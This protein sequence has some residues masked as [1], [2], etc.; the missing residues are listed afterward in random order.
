MDKSN[1]MDLVEL[2][3]VGEKTAKKLSNAGY[4]LNDVLK[5]DG[6]EL[7]KIVGLLG[8]KIARANKPKFYDWLKSSL[9]SAVSGLNLFKLF[10][11]R[12]KNFKIGIY[13]L[14]N[15][16]KTTLANKISED[17]GSEAFGKVSRI[18][19]ETRSVNEKEGLKLNIGKKTLNIDLFDT[20][21]FIHKIDYKTFLKYRIKKSEAMKRTREASLGVIEAIKLINKLNFVV[22]VIDSSAELKEQMNLLLLSNLKHKKIPFL[23]VA[24]KIDL[25]K[26]EEEKVR[27]MFNE[28]LVI[29]ISAKEGINVDFLYKSMLKKILS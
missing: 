4:I 22:V 15:V 5:A 1:W 8:F 13:G 25:K 7:S 26:S 23:I 27:K 2:K 29:P 19:H 17:C 3:F 10:L 24:N 28:H 21:G 6:N 9:K 14:P 20:P 16:G 18:P 11:L 12:T